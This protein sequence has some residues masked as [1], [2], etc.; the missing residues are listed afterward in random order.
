MSPPS[1]VVRLD[2]P[3]RLQL[4]GNA[5]DGPPWGVGEPPL[6]RSLREE[7]GQTGAGRGQVASCM[8]GGRTR[9]P[10]TLPK[11]RPFLEAAPLRPRPALA[12]LT[13]PPSSRS[14]SESYGQLIGAEGA[15][16]RL[17]SLVR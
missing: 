12:A 9:S 15:E 11:G 4:P 10:S 17:R 2:V 13:L 14:G 3:R 8:S 16:G 1:N 7:K 6:G 5:R